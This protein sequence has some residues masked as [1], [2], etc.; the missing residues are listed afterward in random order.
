[1]KKFNVN[2]ALFCDHHIQD[3]RGKNS[4][5]GI[6]D[7]FNVAKFPAILPTFCVTGN[8]LVEDEGT[9]NVKLELEIKDAKNIKIGL[10]TP[11]ITLEHIPPSIDGRKRTFNFVFHINGLPF[12][13]PGQYK[14]DILA[15]GEQIK[16]LIL[17]VK[18]VN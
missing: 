6:F 18:G 11:S 14:F 7:N 5:I 2:Y 1:M 17:D 15:D 8:V 4:I 12:K 16:E 13:E 9:K 3:T 10:N